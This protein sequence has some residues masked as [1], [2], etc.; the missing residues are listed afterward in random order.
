MTDLSLGTNS[1][2]EPVDLS[3]WYYQLEEKSLGP[4]TDDQFQ[5]LIWKGEVWGE[6]PVRRENWESWISFSEIQLNNTKKHKSIAFAGN[7][8]K[9][10]KT[11]RLGVMFISIEDLFTKVSKIIFKAVRVYHL[12]KLFLGVFLLSPFAFALSFLLGGNRVSQ[13]FLLAF[14][15]AAA[16]LPSIFMLARER[17]EGF[18]Q[19]MMVCTVMALSLRYILLSKFIGGVLWPILVF[20]LIVQNLLLLF[21][22]YVFEK[23]WDIPI[24]V[25]YRINLIEFFIF[26]V[27]VVLTGGR[28]FT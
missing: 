15:V 17:Y 23:D 5:E 6:M 21:V 11:S 20:L 26:I 12:E 2:S 22:I 27:L 7:K 14:I 13:Y 3:R 9:I 25:S 18:L 1:T 24:R 16:V 10:R 19:F 8:S 28:P 4:F